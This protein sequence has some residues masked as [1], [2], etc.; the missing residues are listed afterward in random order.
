ML[1]EAA[2][3]T[4]VPQLEAVRS[5]TGAA[6]GRG[7][8]GGGLPAR[9]VANPATCA[10]ADLLT[11]HAAVLPHLPACACSVPGA[12]GGACRLCQPGALF[13]AQRA[14]GDAQPQAQGGG[15]EPGAAPRG[16][17]AQGGWPAGVAAGTSDAAPPARCASCQVPCHSMPARSMP[18]HSHTHSCRRWQPSSRASCGPLTWTSCGPASPACSLAGPPRSCRTTWAAAACPAWTIR[19]WETW[20]VSGPAHAA[21]CTCCVHLLLP[22][23]AAAAAAPCNF[24]AAPPCPRTASEIPPA[25]A[26][27]PPPCPP[28][29]HRQAGLRAS[30]R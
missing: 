25:S 19:T 7:C 20:P 17:R 27:A 14:P 18:A 15:G 5:L 28:P 23:P 26:P 29:A 2:F 13:P 11:T 8:G 9:Q 16:S 21:A 22:L 6:V 3:F 12:G 24:S 4:E 10:P 1:G 30:S